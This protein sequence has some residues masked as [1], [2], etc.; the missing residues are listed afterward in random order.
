MKVKIELDEMYPVPIILTIEDEGGSD[1]E[2]PP[3][4]LADYE[5]AL[6]AFRTAK[7]AILKYLPKPQ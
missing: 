3:E 2:V 4:V 5:N 1:V 7:G 6:S